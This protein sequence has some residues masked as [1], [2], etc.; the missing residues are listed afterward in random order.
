MFDFSDY[1]LDSTFFDPVN[2]IVIGK[3]K[4]EFKG[5]IISEFVGW[6]SKMYSL[7]AV[8]GEEV[9]KAKEVNK[10][11][12]KNIRCKTFVDALFNTKVMRHNIERI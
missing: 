8:D 7:V 5:K 3:M 11:V 12:V 6:K 2:K 4:G 10:S 1:P 9:K